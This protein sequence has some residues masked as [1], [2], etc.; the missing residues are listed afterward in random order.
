MWPYHTGS[1]SF[2]FFWKDGRTHGPAFQRCVCVV[3]SRC[4][5]TGKWAVVWEGFILT[6]T[7]WSHSLCCVILQCSVTKAQ[8]WNFGKIHL[9]CLWQKKDKHVSVHH[10]G[11]S[12]EVLYFRQNG[13]THSG[14]MWVLFF[15]FSFF[16]SFD[17]YLFQPW[18]FQTVISFKRH[19]PMYVYI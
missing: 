10:R 6:V 7:R 8:P 17:Y 1:D 3:V 13:P 4:P 11:C 14:F 18:K 9:T 5:D 19:V 12:G 16:A 2:V 15:S